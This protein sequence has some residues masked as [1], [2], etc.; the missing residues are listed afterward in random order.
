MAI[1]LKDVIEFYNS[2]INKFVFNKNYNKCKLLIFTKK[3]RKEKPLSMHLSM[4]MSVC[5]ETSILLIYFACP[6]RTLF[7]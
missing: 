6:L 4:Y 3:E 1:K 7:N 5:S 2:L